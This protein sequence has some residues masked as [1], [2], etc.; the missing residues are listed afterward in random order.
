MRGSCDT[1]VI[2]LVPLNLN[3]VSIQQGDSKAKGEL[4]YFNLCGF[5]WSCEHEI[6]RICAG[7]A[8]Q[9]CSNKGACGPVPAYAIIYCALQFHV[10]FRG[11]H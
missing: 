8:G 10:F 2:D 3:V 6:A 11:L 5:I 9:C 7:A 1:N 4:D